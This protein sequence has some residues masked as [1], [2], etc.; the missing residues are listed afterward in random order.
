M[1]I[2]LQLPGVSIRLRMYCPPPPSLESVQYRH[3]LSNRCSVKDYICT[4]LDVLWP[5]ITWRIDKV[6][7]VLLPL[8]VYNTDTGCIS[9]RYSVTQTTFVQHWCTLGLGLPGVSIRLRMYCSPWKVY[10]TDTDWAFT[11]IPRS[12]STW[13]TVIKT[14]FLKPGIEYF[15]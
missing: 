13:K 6:E 8:E 15:F 2:D 14:I 7:N 9:N 4:A 3:G 10:N 12:R 1:Y 5:G 11:V